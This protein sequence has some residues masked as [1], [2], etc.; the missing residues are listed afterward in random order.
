MHNT[1]LLIAY[2]GRDYLGWQKTE[3]G[4]SIEGTLQLVL[5]Q[6]FQEPIQL[7]AASRTDAGVHAHGQVVNFLTNKAGPSPERLRASLNHLLP[8]DIVVISVEEVPQSF[9]PTIDC[10]SKEYRYYLCLGPVQMPHNRFYS[11]HVPYELDVEEME[12]G[13]TILVGTHDFSAFCNFKKNASYTDFIRTVDAIHIDRIDS[14]RLE[15]RIIGNRFLYKMV[16]NLVGTLVYVG[17][18]KLSVDDLVGIL[19]RGDRT[20]A[21][22]TAPAHGLFLHKVHYNKDG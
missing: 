1:K 5:E 12:Q 7:Q 19:E 2:D 21:G 4:P 17:R 9:H 14:H 18:G 20:Q 22:V 8:K 16:R 11:W 10:Q 13:A 15:I 6:I 3:C